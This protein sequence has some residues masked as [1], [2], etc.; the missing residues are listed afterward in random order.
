MKCE[1]GARL[2]VLVKEKTGNGARPGGPG[3]FGGGGGGG[4]RGGDRG[5][6]R[7]G[8]V[9]GYRGRGGEGRGRNGPRG[10]G[11]FG[12]RGEGG[13]GEGGRG[14]GGR[15][16]GREAGVAYPS[17][18][19]ILFCS[20]VPWS[21]IFSQSAQKLADQKPLYFVWFM[22]R[23]LCG[24]RAIFTQRWRWGGGGGRKELTRF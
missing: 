16:E 24:S 9:R 5:G 3:R 17:S 23:S 12:G 11:R 1:G 13:R 8:E 2:Q 14:E 15:G 7:G 20:S 6:D 21:T 18:H 10:E 22:S 4:G 19:P